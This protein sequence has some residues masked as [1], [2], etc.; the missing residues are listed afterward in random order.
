MRKFV[1][2]RLSYGTFIVEHRIVIVRV[3]QILFAKLSN[4]CALKSHKFVNFGF[5]YYTD[6]LQVPNFPLHPN[7]NRAQQFDPFW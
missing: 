4:N 5:I 2:N 6:K 7:E 1:G 3:E